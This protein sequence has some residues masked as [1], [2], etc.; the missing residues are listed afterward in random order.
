MK[1]I[2]EFVN[3]HLHKAPVDG[4]K[5]INGLAA[6]VEAAMSQSPFGG[7]L[8]VFT[9]KRRD[10]IK[11]L[12]WNRSGFALWIYRLEKEKFCWPSKIDEDVIA[13]TSRE[14]DWLLEGLDI[15]RIK[16]HETL[17]YSSVS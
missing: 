9:T 15:R 5:Q 6:I 3:I 16:P 2:N 12:Y 7:G 1:S 17:S 10:V 4:R 8:F 13:V 14:L 11:L